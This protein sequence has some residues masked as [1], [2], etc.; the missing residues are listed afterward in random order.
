MTTNSSHLFFL[1]THHASLLSLSTSF[2][3]ALEKY[4]FSGGVERNLNAES[5]S[6]SEVPA[7]ASMESSIQRSVRDIHHRAWTSDDQLSW[8]SWRRKIPNQNLRT[9][10]P[11]FNPAVSFYGPCRLHCKYDLCMSW[12]LTESADLA[13]VLQL[14]YGFVKEPTKCD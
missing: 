14:V 13:F 5:R 10:S 7:T 1:Y 3:V 4:A 9:I 6:K 12:L 2:A 8:S 11:M